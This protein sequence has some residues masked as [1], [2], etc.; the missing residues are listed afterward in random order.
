MCDNRAMDQTNVADSPF[1]LQRR[2][3]QQGLFTRRASGFSGAAAER[4]FQR[5][6]IA[7]FSRSLFFLFLCCSLQE[8]VRAQD[9]SFVTVAGDVGAG[10]S[11]GTNS[12]A[13]L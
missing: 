5:I 10:S 2:V 13:R 1:V 9:Y 12:G 7:S 3:K 11:D 6:A 4:G 8:P